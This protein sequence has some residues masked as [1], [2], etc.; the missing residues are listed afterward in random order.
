MGDDQVT[1]RVFSGLTLRSSL[2]IG[3]SG[4]PAIN[5]SSCEFAC[6]KPVPFLTFTRHKNQKLMPGL[7]TTIFPRIYARTH[8][9][10]PRARVMSFSGVVAGG[11]ATV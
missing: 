11:R 3:I 9:A 8:Y 5:C 6:I 7:I 10:P 2:G 4:S 1:F